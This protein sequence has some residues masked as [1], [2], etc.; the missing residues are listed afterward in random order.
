MSDVVLDDQELDDLL[1]KLR[2]QNFPDEEAP[3]FEEIEA[4][5]QHVGKLGFLQLGF[6]HQ[7]VAFVHETASDWYERYE[8]L[9]EAMEEFGISNVVF[10]EDSEEEL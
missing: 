9:I 8:E 7:G 1:G 5:R 3:E 6:V 4:L 10:D 2:E